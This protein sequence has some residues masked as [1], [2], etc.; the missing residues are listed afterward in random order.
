M[1]IFEID[2]GITGVF[3]KLMIIRD[4]LFDFKRKF[5]NIGLFRNCSYYLVVPYSQIL[6]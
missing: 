1:K 6:I 5:Y 2:L 3:F 4:F